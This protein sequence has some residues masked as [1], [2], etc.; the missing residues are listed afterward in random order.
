[1]QKPS[2][3]TVQ[4]KTKKKPAI[5]KPMPRRK[6]RLPAQLTKANMDKVYNTVKYSSRI[7]TAKDLFGNHLPSGH[8]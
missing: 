7:E 4:Q 1:M 3:R 2:K 5:K 8:K 6:L